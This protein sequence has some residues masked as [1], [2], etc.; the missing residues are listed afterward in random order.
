MNNN[1]LKEFSTNKSPILSSPKYPKEIEQKEQKSFLTNFF[2]FKSLSNIVP[3]EKLK[4]SQENLYTEKKKKKVKETLKNS[5][6]RR[7]AKKIIMRRVEK[8]N[9]LLDFDLILKELLQNK[10]LKNDLLGIEP[11]RPIQRRKIL[12]K[13]ILGIK[14]KKINEKCLKIINKK[15]NSK[16]FN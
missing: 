8:N 2:P 14:R 5:F 4:I 9:S 10:N 12:N 7:I 6:K 3:S 11:S 13:K 15:E 1:T 16:I